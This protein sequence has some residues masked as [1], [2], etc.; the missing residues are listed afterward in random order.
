MSEIPLTVPEP[1]RLAAANDAVRTDLPRFAPAAVEW[2]TESIADVTAA[3]RAAVDD[4]PALDS[5]PPGAEIAITAGSRGIRDFP[6]MLAGVIE[7]LQDSG[8]EPFV[9]PSMGSHGGA[10]ADGQ[11][12]VLADLG[13]TP[14]S[15]G[16]P[17]RSS[18]ATVEV[19]QDDDRTV[20]VDAHAADAD[21]I[22][23]AN[24]V[25]PHTDFT[26]TIE[27]GLCKMAVIGMGKHDGAE[28]MHNA[29]LR[30]DMGNE[31]RE[32]A[33]ILFDE[34]PIIG[35]IALVEN[36]HDRAT[37]IEGVPTD[38]ILE[39]EAELLERAYRELPMLPVEDLDLLIVDEM[40]K[41][42]SGTGLDT[43][44]IGRTYFEG[45][46]EPE[47]PKYTRIYVRSLTPPSHGNGL[48]I[49]LA[50]MVH[51]DLVRDLDLGDTYVNIATSGETKRTKIPLIVPD[52][53]SAL[54]LAPSI[55]GTP[56]PEELRIARIPNTMEPGQL[57]V[58]EPVANDL[59]DHE[60]VTVGELRD[61]E[62]DDGT[63]S[64][65]PYGV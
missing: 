60:S 48:G 50:D 38:Q 19:G 34:L 32:R 27:S 35:G 28:M 33:A 7:A 47:R 23:I 15:L 63:L 5:L 45:E 39:R 17:V 16:C 4:L 13:M 42:V 54:L 9:F 14:D 41:E 30:G 1:E 40:G 49:G 20:Y 37:H 21:A 3:G 55:T 64:S 2:E 62:L 25:K 59:K 61:L 36:A 26:D 10:T 8:Y 51:E 24:R 22:L 12:A 6:P 53:E 46:T 31:I 57:F 56:D 58:S 43:N 11:R 29:G 18:M 52:D 44:V 65:D